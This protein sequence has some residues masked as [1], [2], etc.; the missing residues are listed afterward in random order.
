VTHWTSLDAIQS[1][2]GAD[3]E[4]AVV[5]ANVQRMMLEYDRRA[6]HFEVVV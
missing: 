3:A 2:A 6:R 5:P 4:V 1:F